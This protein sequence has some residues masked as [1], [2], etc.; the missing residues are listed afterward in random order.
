MR[1]PDQAAI[2]AATAHEHATGQHRS[3][4]DD[5]HSATSAPVKGRLEVEEGGVGV[6]EVI[7]ATGVCTAP[8]FPSLAT[9]GVVTQLL[10][11]VTDPAGTQLVVS[12][13]AMPGTMAT[14]ATARLAPTINR[15]AHIMVALLPVE[16]P[17]PR[18]PKTRLPTTRTAQDP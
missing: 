1:P 9:V 11:S 12:A 14:E 8:S 6:T 2:R 18:S 10:G 3:G 7:G 15:L 13:L 17:P 4:A 5:G 16:A